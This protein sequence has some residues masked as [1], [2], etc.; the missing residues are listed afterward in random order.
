M[1]ECPPRVP[2]KRTRTFFDVEMVGARG[3]E[4]PTPCTPCRC[5]TR[6]RYAPTLSHGIIPASI[7]GPQELANFFDDLPQLV[8]RKCRGSAHGR[9]GDAAVT[10]FRCGI[11]R[12]QPVARAVDG[13]SLLVEQVA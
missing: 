13:K 6:L 11:G 4:P 5:A 7:A 12:F 8:R 3:I 1:G 10:G 2:W 9:T